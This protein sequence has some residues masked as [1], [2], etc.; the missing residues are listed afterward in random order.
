MSDIHFSVNSFDQDGDLYEKGIYL[1]FGV[2]SIKV[3]EDME[4]YNKFIVEIQS[5]GEEIAEVYAIPPTGDNDSKSYPDESP[6]Q[7]HEDR[8]ILKE[9]R[10]NNSIP[11]GDKT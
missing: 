6:Y 2:A 10:A 11:T 9:Q 3:A 5:M 1:H 7:S 8:L 4:G